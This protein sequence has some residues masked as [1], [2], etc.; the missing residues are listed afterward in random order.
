LT[1][2]TVEFAYLRTVVPMALLPLPL[3]CISFRLLAV[4][5]FRSVLKLLFPFNPVPRKTALHPQLNVPPP[6]T[7]LRAVYLRRVLTSV[8]PAECPMRLVHAGR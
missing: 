4:I 6:R 2:R 3:V 7:E 8:L 1:S 5:T